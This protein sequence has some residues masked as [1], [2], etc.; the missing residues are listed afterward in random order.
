MVSKTIDE[1]SNPSSPAKH[2]K[3]CNG[4]FCLYG[5]ITFLANGCDSFVVKI[6]NLIQLD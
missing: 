3:A 2:K 6:E 4:F 1:G 5:E